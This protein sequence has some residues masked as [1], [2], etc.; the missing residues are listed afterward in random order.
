VD[1]NSANGAHGSFGSYGQRNVD[2]IV[3]EKAD[4]GSV[5]VFA[6]YARQTRQLSPRRTGPSQV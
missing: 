4:P 1:T 2:A 6:Q 3:Q 5:G